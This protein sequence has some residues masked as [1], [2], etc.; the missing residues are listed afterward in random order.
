M[1]FQ[2]D[3]PDIAAFRKE[4]RD[5]LETNLPQDWRHHLNCLDQGILRQWQARLHARGW[6][7]PNWPVS[8]GGM[9]ASLDQ[10]LVLLEEQ[11][12]VGAPYLFPTGLNLLGPTFITFGTQEQKE[13]FLPPLL[14]AEM[15]WA[16]GYSETEAGS[17][18]AALKTTARVDGLDFIID[19]HKIWSSY[20]HMADWM[21]A[22]VRTDPQAAARQAGLS[23]L[24]IDLRSAGISIRPIRTIA[25]QDEFSEVRFDG[26]RVPQANLLGPLNGGWKVANHVLVSERLSNGSP[27]SILIVWRKLRRVA[28][29]AGLWH[30]VVFRDTVAAAE[31]RLVAHLALY[32]QA[33]D[34]VKSG[35]S[36]D[37]LAPVMKIS[38]TELLQRFNALLLDA[39]AEQGGNERFEF[40]DGTGIDLAASRLLARRGSIYGGSNE[41]QRNIIAAR[42]LGMPR[43]W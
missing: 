12:R 13:R 10:Q 28:R 22:L 15:V 38:A 27:R 30:D 3:T 23:M 26:V 32:R 9:G 4:V 6:V 5:W 34:H 7:A 40:D 2:N 21:F 35:R 33:V 25:G 17:D 37:A 43:S 39:A 31:V 36:I 24:L 20:A 1:L 14:S 18:L 11:T 19:G 29:A 42:V 41:I 16:Q 8:A